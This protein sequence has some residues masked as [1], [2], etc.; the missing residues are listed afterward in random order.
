MIPDS[1]CYC[2][3]QFQAIEVAPFEYRERH[4]EP[5]SFRPS[6]FEFLSAIRCWAGAFD[7]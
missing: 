7:V 3:S 1:Q 6:E 2:F 4:F 5:V